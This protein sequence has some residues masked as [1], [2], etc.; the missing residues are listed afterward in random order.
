MESLSLLRSKTILLPDHVGGRIAADLRAL[1]F[2]VAVLQDRRWTELSPR[3]RVLSI[4]DYNQDGV[5]L[6][7][8]DGTLLVN[9]NDAAD[10][11]WGGFVKRTIRSYGD[12]FLLKL[13][14]YGDADMI[15][16]MDEEGQRIEPDAGERFP[17]G[18]YIQAY[19]EASGVRH[20]VPFSSLH[21]YQ[22]RDSVWAN[23]Y[24]TRVE[25]YPVGFSST[26]A[27]LWPAY[28]SYDCRTRCAQAIQPAETPDEALDPRLFGDDWDEPLEQADVRKLR[29][30]FRS[31]QRLERALDFI[32]LRVGGREHHVEFT[33]RG[34]RTGVIFE[35][36]RHSLMEAVTNEAFDD[37]LIGNFMKTCL[38]GEWP[39]SGLY[40]HFTPY[41]AKYA[42][43]GRAK[44]DR[45]LRR[46]FSLYRQ[47]APLSYLRHCVEIALTN[48]FRRR[49]S[50]HSPVFYAARRAWKYAVGRL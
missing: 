44:T 5:L 24:V 2:Q 46:Y 27:T 39:K 31:I 6:V 9:L 11:G 47:R 23:R 45:D 20:V 15:N 10:H 33:S 40:P 50:A 29:L 30:Y 26:N 32:A 12:T 17:L 25:D 38:V 13:F 18:A 41:V 42:D 4:S 16:F 35:A 8:L 43:N 21:K 1:D 34:F 37:L 28:L 49:V 14:G 22:R 48:A 36:P 19:A 7:D 3:L